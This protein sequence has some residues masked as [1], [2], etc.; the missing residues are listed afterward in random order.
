MTEKLRKI[1]KFMVKYGT[2]NGNMIKSIYRR[3]ILGLGTF[4]QGLLQFIYNNWLFMFFL[5][6]ALI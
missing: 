2:Y 5:S 1:I 3:N 4:R 6:S